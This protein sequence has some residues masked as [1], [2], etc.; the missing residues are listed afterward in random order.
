[1]K[2]MLPK[3]SQPVSLEDMDK[4]VQEGAQNL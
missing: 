2:G 4:A 3:P 1:L